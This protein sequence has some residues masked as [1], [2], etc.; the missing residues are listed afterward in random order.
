MKKIMVVAI[1]LACLMI[2]CACNC[3][4]KTC[5]E[6][7][8][9]NPK[10][11]KDCNETLGEALGHKWMDADCTTPRTCQNCAETEGEALGHSWLE[12]TTEQPKTCEFCAATEGERI[13]TDERFKTETTKALYGEWEAQLSIPA[14]D[15]VL[16]TESKEDIV[17]DCVFTF[18][19]DGTVCQTVRFADWEAAKPVF[20][21]TVMIML[22]QELAQQG[23]NQEEADVAIQKEYKM[24]MEEYALAYLDGVDVSIMEQDPVEMV[25]YVEGANL[26]MGYTWDD[27]MEVSQFSIDGNTLTLVYGD[28]S[29]KV[30]TRITE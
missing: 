27:E 1:A 23:M 14:G 6:A 7:D 16:L 21:E 25:Y 24:T 20:K 13:V 17:Y 4:H 15:V 28:G 8:C 3:G 18:R 9:L 30:L 22:Y 5:V 29:T 2:L 26:H 19:N 10:I 11:C 12:A